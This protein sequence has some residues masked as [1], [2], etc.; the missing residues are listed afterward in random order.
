MSTRLLI[1]EELFLL[2]TRDDGA[3]EGFGTAR[4]L[5]L[6]AALLA[7]LAELGAIDVEGPPKRPSVSVRP[8]DATGEDL[9]DDAHARLAAKRHGRAIS[10]LIKDTK[11]VPDDRVG[12]RLVRAEILRHEPARMLGLVPARWPVL[13][14]SA[15][16]AVRARLLASLHG[17]GDGSLRDT[18]LL[19]ALH[20]L[21]VDRAV[22]DVD[23]SRREFA[24]RMRAFRDA[25]P[26]AAAVTKVLQERAAA[27]SAAAA[28]AAAA[29]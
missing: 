1:C 4:Q 25:S 26:F 9:L 5:G 11:L 18:T 14:P 16:A 15:E 8:W 3:K 21:R 22:L 24:K 27:A 2:L 7:D 12:S 20:A 29:S 10:S 19:G 6:A 17:D 28:G 13:D 23:L